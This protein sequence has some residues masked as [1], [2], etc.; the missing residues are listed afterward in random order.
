MKKKIVSV[1]AI[2]VV[3]AVVCAMPVV[4]QSKVP[5]EVTGEVVYIPFPVTITLDG[6]TDDWAGIPIQAVDRG[7]KKSPHSKQNRVFNFAVAADDA[8]LYVYMHSVDAKIVTGKHGKDF[9]NEDSMEFY[10]NLSGDL[11]AAAY[12]PGIFQININPGNIGKNNA[13]LTVIGTNSETVKVT[14]SVFATEDG[15]AFE[16]AVPLGSFKPE[17]GKTVGFQ[18]QANGTTT[19]DRD[20]KLIWSKADKADASYNKP[21]VFGK[22]V[23]FKVG[24]TDVPKAQ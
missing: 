18:A 22:A 10:F 12:K 7:P 13:E 21:N 3:L 15:W 8:N 4:A 17:H 6:K 19:K 2:V 9:W 14:G 24:S 23:F 1:F 16:A 11:A 5:A 20:S